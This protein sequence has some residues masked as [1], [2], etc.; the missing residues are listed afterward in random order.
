[1]L[2]SSNFKYISKVV[3]VVVVVVFLKMF[4]HQKPPLKTNV[5]PGRAQ[6]GLEAS[7][8][9]NRARTAGTDAEVTGHFYCFLVS[10]NI[11]QSCCKNNMIYVCMM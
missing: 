4:H 9:A 5:R 11:K 2:E 3:V 7:T 6:A 1:M 10:K 8:A